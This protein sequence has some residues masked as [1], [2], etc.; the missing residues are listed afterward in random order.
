MPA[1]A[2][3]VVRLLAA[4]VPALAVASCA[5]A[6]SSDPTRDVG[7]LTG[8]ASQHVAADHTPGH[9]QGRVGD[10]SIDGDVTVPDR[11]TCELD[12]TRVE[13][14]VSVGHGARL[15]A[16]GVDVDGD[17]EGEGAAAVEVTD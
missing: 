16:R 13:G 1:T 3:R 15:V 8:S 9:C 10:V 7:S 14:N 6:G 4:L 12:G 2:F 11:A 17:V 5:S